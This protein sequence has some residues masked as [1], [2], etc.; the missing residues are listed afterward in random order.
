LR[1]IFIYYELADPAT[2]QLLRSGMSFIIALVSILLLQA[3]LSKLQWIAIVF[4][5]LYNL[6]ES[7][8]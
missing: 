8:S 3:A 1:Q 7:L 4:Q 6:P 2:I 5:V